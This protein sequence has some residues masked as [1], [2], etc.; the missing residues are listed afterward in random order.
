MFS[1]WLNYNILAINCS[2]P[3]KSPASKSKRA[4]TVFFIINEQNIEF[5]PKVQVLSYELHDLT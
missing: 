2:E 4:T 1:T 5:H 3:L